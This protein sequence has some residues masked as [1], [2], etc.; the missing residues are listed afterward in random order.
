[1]ENNVFKKIVATALVM[2]L[3]T[4]AWACKQSVSTGWCTAN[5]YDGNN[6]G[7]G[8]LITPGIVITCPTVHTGSVTLPTST[9]LN[10]LIPEACVILMLAPEVCTVFVV[11][12]HLAGPS[13]NGM[14]TYPVTWTTYADTYPYTTINRVLTHTWS[15]QDAPIGVT[16]CA[17]YDFACRSTVTYLDCDAILVTRDVTTGHVYFF[18]AHG[19]ACSGA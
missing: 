7:P 9:A 1:M 18:I 11:L 17:E 10:R 6:A 12:N 5:Y 2:I 4:S 8:S 15:C 19:D 13:I 14:I 3:T 16:G